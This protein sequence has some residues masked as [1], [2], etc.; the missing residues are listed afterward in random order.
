MPELKHTAFLFDM[1]S[2]KI[3]GRAAQIAFI[4]GNNLQ[5]QTSID[6]MGMS[7][8]RTYQEGDG[9]CVPEIKV[10]WYKMSRLTQEQKT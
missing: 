3:S 2:A 4:L 8:R 5:I 7:N 6:M 9:L 10:F 1:K